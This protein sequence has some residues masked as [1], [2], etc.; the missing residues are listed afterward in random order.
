MMARTDDNQERDRENLKWMM[1][2]MIAKRD[3]SHKKMIATLDAH[4]ESIMASL[5]KTKASDFKANQEEM[6]SVTEH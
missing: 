3:A 5:G 6:E 1:E 2:E 4:R